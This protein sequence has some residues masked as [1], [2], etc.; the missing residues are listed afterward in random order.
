[1]GNLPTSARRRLSRSQLLETA[2]NRYQRALAAVPDLSEARL[3]LARVLFDRGRAVDALE[4][5]TPLFALADSRVLYLARLFAGAA[6]E[7]LQRWRE[8]SAHY[9]TAVQVRPELATPRIALSHA[10]RHLGD[11]AGAV[12]EAEEALKSGEGVNDP[13]WGYYFG[14]G[15]LAA[16]LGYELIEEVAR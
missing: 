16:R 2:E 6:C 13:W 14:Q 5:L 3:R 10:L 4:T 12:A 7:S 1:M 8:A 9:R 11:M 15:L